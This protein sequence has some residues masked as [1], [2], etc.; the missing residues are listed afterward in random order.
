VRQLE[1]M[2]Q[3]NAESLA[4]LYFILA[5]APETAAPAT[6]VYEYWLQ[7]KAAMLQ[8]ITDIFNNTNLE[9]SVATLRATHRA[10]LMHMKNDM[11]RQKLPE[12]EKMRN[13]KRYILHGIWR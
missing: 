5:V 13:L 1:G 12:E 6:P 4:A 11:A 8:Q 3:N 9:F 7:K 10:E 2:H